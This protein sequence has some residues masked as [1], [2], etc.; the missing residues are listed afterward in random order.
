MS[1]E[2]AIMQNKL[3]SMIS[4]KAHDI[5]AVIERIG[6]TGNMI[7]DDTVAVSNLQFSHQATGNV[8]VIYPDHEGNII[9]SRIHDHAFAHLGSKFG[10]PRGF[11]KEMAHGEMW[12]KDLAAHT[13]SEFSSNVDRDRLLLRSVEGEVRAAV[14]DRYRRLNS[15]KIFMT[16]LQAAQAT[17][18]R[19]VDAYNGDTRA[20][21][22]VINPEVV[23]FDTPLNGKNYGVFGARIRNSDFGHGALELRSFMLNVACLNGMVGETQLHEVHLGGVIP[24]NIEISNETVLKDTEARA[25]LVADTMNSIYSLTNTE[26]MIESIKGA[27]SREIDIQEETKRL[28]KLG[29][30]KM[31]VEAFTNVLLNNNPDDGVQGGPSMW[32]FVNG[33]TAVA[34]DS[35]PERKRELEKIAGELLG[36]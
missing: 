21:M 36:I 26:R 33:L 1:N 11:L 29:V 19:L 6:A 28:P 5:G 3:E 13:L 16:F 27:S 2:K 10:I 32:K 9:Q 7:D 22:E 34:R 12:Q 4:K 31:E 24:E 15:M 25:S 17:G 14:S 30:S 35:K 8:E 18:S 23:E 20:Y